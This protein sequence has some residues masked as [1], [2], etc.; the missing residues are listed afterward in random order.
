MEY[1]R[2]IQQFFNEV[3]VEF[4]KVNWPSR[5]MILNST[6]VVLVVTV[7][8]GFFLWAVDWGLSRVVGAILR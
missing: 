8:I 5:P 2:R 3:M 1:L 7:I 6:T 4:R